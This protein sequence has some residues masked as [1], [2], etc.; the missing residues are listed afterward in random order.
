MKEVLEYLFKH[1]TLS[2]EEAKEI[3]TKISEGNFNA[4]QISSFLTVFR[5]RGITVEELKGF[6]DA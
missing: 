5:M 6:R 2:S 4:Y 3:L 1:N